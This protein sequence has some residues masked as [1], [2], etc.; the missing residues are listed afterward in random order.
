MKRLSAL[1]L[2]FAL[3]HGVG[4][5]ETSL[6]RLR[7]S[8]NHRFLVIENGAPFFWLGD[9]AWHLFG[10]SA[11]AETTNQPP[12]SLYFSN[13]AAK[14]FTV[15]QSVVVRWPDGGTSAN[16]YGFEPFAGLQSAA[17]FHLDEAAR[18][19]LVPD[20]KAGTLVYVPLD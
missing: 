16:A 17:D 9:T 15:V 12:V 6:P 19:L 4:L 14:G 3:S 1:L 13:R 8:D 2:L 7:V 18:L 10:K 5:A 11:R 20:M